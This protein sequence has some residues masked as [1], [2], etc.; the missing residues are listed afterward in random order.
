MRVSVTDSGPGL[1]EEDMG[2]LFRPYA[3]IRAGEMQNGGGTGLGLCICKSFVE[4]HGGGQIGVTSEG[5]GK[6]STF[7]FQVFLPLV[8]GASPKVRTSVCF[9]PLAS[10]GAAKSEAEGTSASQTFAR[11]ST[12]RRRLITR[13][14][15]K[16]AM[17]KMLGVEEPQRSS[18]PED[19]TPVP[20]SI[21]Q[22]AE[23]PPS[24][25]KQA[26]DSNAPDLMSS[27]VAYAADVLLVD[28]DQFCL[29]AGKAAIKRLGYSVKTAADGDEAVDIIVRRG[30]N[31]RLVLMD[32]NMARMNGPVAL[33]HIHN[34]FCA[35]MTAAASEREKRLNNKEE[36]DEKANHSEAEE[37][38]G[39]SSCVE[40]DDSDFSPPTPSC[41]PVHIPLLLGC[42]GD[43]NSDHEFLS[44]GA[45]RVIHK[46]LRAS[47]LAETLQSL[48][49]QTLDDEEENREV[50][51][52]Q[53]ETALM[54]HSKEPT[55]S[56]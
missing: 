13:L 31:F 52:K 43:T 7:F 56:N 46:P 38:A 42:T 8:R 48:R 33:Q 45:A 1:S 53:S 24:Q 49:R 35:Q 2:R 12:P 27:M 3:Q 39:D 4:A 26:E 29:L 30:L 40:V 11:Q 22:A 21:Q 14:A 10:P 18:S 6:G 28:D 9:S 47:D 50:E 32:N 17:G 16:S 55:R 5:P 41:P 44:A 34:H 20:L 37:A 15:K 54:T 19:A 51:H 25:T 36:R 23:Q